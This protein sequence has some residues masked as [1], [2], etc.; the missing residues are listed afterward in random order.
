MKILTRMVGII[1]LA[2][3]PFTSHARLLQII[4]TNDLH[5]YFV[6]YENGTGGYARL[7]TKIKELRENAKS[8][9]VDVLQLDG[10]D[11]GEG[12]S[13][14]LS[15]QGHASFK[16]LGMMGVDVAV[17]GNHDHMEGGKVLGEQIRKANVNTKFLAANMVTT[18]D[19]E[20]GGLVKGSLDL[21]K[22]GIKIRVI[23]LTTSEVHFQHQ[24]KPGFILPPIPVADIESKAARKAGRELVIAL[25][26][27][28]KSTDVKLAKGTSE[29]DLIVGGHSHDR[30]E[31]VLYV[32][33]K[34]KKDIPIVQAG[35]HALTVGDLL[36]DYKDDGSVEIVNYKLHEIK[37]PQAEDQ[38]MASLVSEAAQNRNQYFG[39]RWD[40][41]IGDST[42]ALAGSLA[43]KA[44]L[45]GTCWGRH[46]GRM[47]RDASE[48]DIGIH[49][50]LF[51]GVYKS[52][53]PITYGDLIDNFPHVRKFG[54]PGWSISTVS[55]KGSILK[56]LLGIF[57]NLRDIVGI[58]F[59]GA[60]YKSI[61][62]PDFIPYLGG[63]IFPFGYKI[64]GEKID[65]DRMYK[66][67]FPTEVGYALKTLMP[68]IA[69]KLF[70]DLTDTGKYYWPVMEEYVKQNSPISCMEKN[71]FN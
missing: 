48:S 58:Q 64:N 50:A 63:R 61:V 45:Q 42:V 16:A 20:L 38:E 44:V 2:A 14:F 35:A 28:G 15:D 22:G 57:I 47:T 18:Q 32:K 43:G 8:K 54:D 52:P 7:V 39:N 26:H 13:F 10:G 62:I 40:E 5:S 49:L 37:M 55:V 17:I 25:T 23:G 11:F 66:I 60:Q 71:S 24:I 34:N 1:A 67:S 59:Y 29:V 21:E 4:H 36:I 3:I 65:K 56:T 30:I 33:N 69:Q 51:E 46:M 19:M 27:I 68:K 6:G 53:G 31:D 12:T 9:G 41:V 70:P